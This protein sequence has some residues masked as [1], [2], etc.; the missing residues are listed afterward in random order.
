MI[1][2]VPFRLPVSKP[3]RCTPGRSVGVVLLVLIAA[4]ASL[5]AACGGS[6]ESSKEASDVSLKVGVISPGSSARQVNRMKSGAFDGAEYSVE[7]VEFATTNDAL[8]ALISGAIDVALLVQSPNAVLAAGNATEPW[9]T[10]TAPFVIVGAALPY[11]E[12]GQLVI[13]KTDS[14]IQSLD[15]LRG[16]SITFPRGSLQQ[17]CWA[18]LRLSNNL[19]DGAVNEVLMAAGEA[20]AAYLSGAIEANV[21][22]SWARSQ[23][24]AG[25]SRS[26]ATCEP[27]VAP[28]YTVTLARARLLDDQA[29]AAAV[30]DLLERSQTAEAWWNDNR[31]E[32]AKT[33]I[34]VASQSVA[35]AAASAKYDNR[36]RVPLD[37]ETIA[38]IQDEADVF[39]ELGVMRT[40][41]DIA[42][43]FDNRFDD[44][45]TRGR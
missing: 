36:V 39:A 11:V 8:P 45:L 42:F 9:T 32:A 19:P 15:D 17:Y 5:L 30:S 44:G 21:A 3:H 37:A 6:T 18:K 26:I 25:K 13:V 41:P 4:C 10:E 2:Q 28:E 1:Q 27:S 23:I 38:A 33:Y 43:L 29:T 35:E 7:W 24:V 12:D 14:P 40:R 20:R 31:D 16:R 22:N 34:E